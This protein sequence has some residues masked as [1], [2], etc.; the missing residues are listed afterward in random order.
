MSKLI[1]KPFGLIAGLGAGFTARK[2]F[3]RVWSVIDNE[4]PPAPDERAAGMRRLALALAIEGAV[5]RLVKGLTEHGS[6]RAFAG[7]TGFWPG[8][9]DKAKKD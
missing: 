8:K 4:R 7:L 9:K 5:F 6:R 3:Q 2:L 1:F